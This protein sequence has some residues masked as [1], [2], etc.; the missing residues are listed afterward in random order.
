MMKKKSAQKQAKKSSKGRKPDYR[1]AVAKEIEGQD[2]PF[3]TTI[4]SGW[5]AKNGISIQLSALPLTDHVMLFVNEDEDG[6]EETD[7]DED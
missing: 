1:L 3:W 6:E 7:S 2:K 5:D 4:G